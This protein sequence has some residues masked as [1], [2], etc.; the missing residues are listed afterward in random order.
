MIELFSGATPN[1]FKVMIALEELGMEYRLTPVDILAGE[2]FAPPFLA[3]N[4]NHR[5][6]A[7]LDHDPADGNVAMPL[8]ESGAILIYLAERAGALL[9]TEPRARAHVIQWVMWQMAGQGPM[10]GQAGH[11][12]NYAPEKLPYAIR[13]YTNEAKRLYRVLDG[14]LG[15]RDY[16]V[17]DYSIADIACW[18]WILFREHHGVELEDY[19]NL[20]RWFRAVEARPAVAQVMSQVT[21]SQ[22]PAFTDEQRAV[23]FGTVK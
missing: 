14:H 18:P 1:V 12:R 3:I 8:F 4:P 11:F 15:G 7:I 21:I 10:V 19:P 20:E 23:L 13:R 6:P 9:P 17:E 2:Q 5:I 16:V 22:P